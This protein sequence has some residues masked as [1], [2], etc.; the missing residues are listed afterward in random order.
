L[1]HSFGRRYHGNDA[2]AD[3]PDGAEELLRELDSSFLAK[4]CLQRERI[5]WKRHQKHMS[6]TAAVR[7]QGARIFIVDDSAVMRRSLRSLLEA[8][9]HWKVCDEA[10]DGQEAVAKFSRGKFDAVVID[11]QMPV[12]NG[13]EAAK[14]ITSNAPDTPILM[15]TMHASSHLEAEA[16]KAGIRGLCAKENIRCVVEG[17]ATILENKTYFQN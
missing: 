1:F 4:S 17:L 9:D 5:E 7:P 2:Q 6:Q 12:M 16:R 13:L 8:Q 10:A 11:F 3:S 14:Q 15:V